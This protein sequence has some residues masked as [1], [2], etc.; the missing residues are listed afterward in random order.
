[1]KHG[2]RNLNRRLLSLGC[3]AV[4]CDPPLVYAAGEGR[5][6]M[7]STTGGI[8]VESEDG[9]FSG[10]LGGRLQIDYAYYH[11]DN[12][13]L[14]GGAEIRRAR[15]V[16]EGRLWDYWDFKFNPD[17]VGNN[18]DI[19]EAW[20]GYRGLEPLSIQMGNIKEP[21]S[22]EDLTSDLYITFMERSLPVEIF[23]PNYSLGLQLHSY[24][25]MWQGSGGIFGEDVDS[26]GTEQ[27]QSYGAASRLSFSPVNEANRVLHLDGA[28]EWRTNY[29]NDEVR[30]R[31]RP[32][33]HITDVRLVDTGEI[34]FVDDTL[35]FDIG[36][37]GVWGPWSLQGE[38]IQTLVSRSNGGEDLRFGGW[39][40]FGSWF[41][42]GES[43]AYDAR[44][45]KF[46]RVKPKSVVGNGGY[47]AWEIAIRVSRVDLNSKEIKGGTQTNVTLGLNWYTTP[48][49]R[50][51]FN[52]V[53]ADAERIDSNSGL[54]VKDNPHILQVRAQVD[55]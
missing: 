19:Q 32:E 41:V 16:A 9:G 51:M 24:G 12:I 29:Q 54:E 18:V 31:G 5:G 28:V 23:K 27:S 40:V 50:L 4:L 15:L 52:Y 21:F 22:V 26:P 35:K 43:R 46:T 25:K 34:A 53:Y 48:H 1:M 44:G 8:K 6:L 7:L 42:T 14:G 39:Y 55:F 20:I 49:T 11:S 13:K 3:L 47:G 2:V 37:A 36:S 30:F 10:R 38:Y 17:F 33:S 45:G